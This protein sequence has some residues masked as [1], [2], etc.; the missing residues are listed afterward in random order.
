MH[1]GFHDRSGEADLTRCP[2]CGRPALSLLRK[3]AL[4]PGRAVKCQSCGKMVMAHWA[5]V[6]AA[7]PAF[8]GGFVLMKSESF[9]LGIAAVAAGLLIMAAIHCYLVPLVRSDA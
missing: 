7:I 4:G 3:S 1:S 5:A 2:H 6:F 8:M 9:P